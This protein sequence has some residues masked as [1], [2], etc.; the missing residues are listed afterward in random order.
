M[1]S[2]LS[3]C[4]IAASFIIVGTV[5]P[6]S[7]MA[8]PPSKLIVYTNVNQMKS[9][10]PLAHKDGRVVLCFEQDGKTL[11]VDPKTGH[12]FSSKSC[13][14]VIEAGWHYAGAIPGT[15][16]VVPFA[17]FLGTGSVS[18]TQ[19]AGCGP[20]FLNTWR[21]TADTGFTSDFYI[22]HKLK[23]PEKYVY[24]CP[25]QQDSDTVPVQTGYLEGQA[26]V[27][28]VD[29]KTSLIS[30]DD[31]LM[32]M[33]G[34]PTTEVVRFGAEMIV[35]ASLVKLSGRDGFRAR[36]RKMSQAL[37]APRHVA[38]ARPIDLVKEIHKQW[39]LFNPD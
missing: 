38:D 1:K 15:D 9:W 32:Q 13:K 2:H 4:L 36:I 8:A 23:S 16:G 18:F 11:V 30:S 19:E 14:S 25:A 27:I 22:V 26:L 28:N 10:H 33:P 20:I 17:T 3:N 31:V 24:P 6:G 34:I 29:E 21:F 39:P 37:A 35:P 7:S 12:E 5:E